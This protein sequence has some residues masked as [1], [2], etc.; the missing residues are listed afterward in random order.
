[1]RSICVVFLLLGS[2]LAPYLPALAAELVSSNYQFGDLRLQYLPP[3]NDGGEQI[4]KYKI[5]W[6][7]SSND[8]LVPPFA[9]S[10]QHFG[11]A[12]V[13]NVREDQEI[14]LSCRS[15]CTGTF[16][17]SWGGRVTDE[18]LRVDATSEEM[19]LALS[20]LLEPFNLHTDASS[21]VRVTRK[22]NGFAFKWRVA[23]L[24]IS[25]DIGLIQAND[26]L[27]IGSGSNVRVVEVTKGSSDLYPGAYANEV[28]TVSVRTLSGNYDT[29]FRPKGLLLL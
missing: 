29:P 9:P 12:E 16:L 22:A 21:P 24:G 25:G 28:Q 20:K 23:F 2:Y 6:D 10:S 8:A 13:A 26:D 19:E 3:E 1:M 18:P 14:I 27:L 11:S 17:L 5:E 15:T 7:A 4:T